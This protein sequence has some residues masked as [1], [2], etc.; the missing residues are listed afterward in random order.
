[1]K[2]DRSEDRCDVEN[3]QKG[4][5]FALLPEPSSPRALDSFMANLLIG[6]LPVHCTIGHDQISVFMIKMGGQP[7]WS[8]A[9]CPCWMFYQLF[10][11]EKRS[12]VK[13]F[14]AHAGCFVNKGGK[15]AGMGCPSIIVKPSKIILAVL[16]IFHAYS[17]S[18]PLLRAQVRLLKVKGRSTCR[19]MLG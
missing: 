3:G 8:R 15:T 18:N 2:S 4:L 9:I 19:A 6:A 5:W 13:I 7:E 1:M 11:S 14:R 12:Y 17:T 10:I 16:N